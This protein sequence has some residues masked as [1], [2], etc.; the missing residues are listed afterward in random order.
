MIAPISNYLLENQGNIKS[1][2][3]VAS[4]CI[5]IPWFQPPLNL[6]VICCLFVIML[7]SV[8]ATISDQSGEGMP[9]P[10]SY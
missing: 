5:I 7:S 10:V 9:R 1:S 4:Y 6:V 3:D 8:P 2:F